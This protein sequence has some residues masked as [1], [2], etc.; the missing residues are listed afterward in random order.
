M[1]AADVEKWLAAAPEGQRAILDALREM[2]RVAGTGVVEEF[3]WGR[4]VYKSGGGLFSYL[5]RT[6][7]HVTLGFHHG[8]ELKDPKGLLEGDG[9][10][11]RHVKLT[12]VAAA[13]D[14]A[15]RRLIKQAAS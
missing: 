12:T 4:P 13:R 14:P 2:I 3:K 5:H 7:N 1:P 15:I 9:K 8:A 11:M 6:K 10:D